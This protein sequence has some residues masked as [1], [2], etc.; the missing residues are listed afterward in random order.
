M[1]LERRATPSRA[2]QL[3]APLLAVAATLAIA[4]LLVAW[5]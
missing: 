2:A 1:H 3:A 5:N 4:A